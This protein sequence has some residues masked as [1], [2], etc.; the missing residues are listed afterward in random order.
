[1]SSVSGIATREMNVSAFATKQENNSL[2]LQARQSTRSRMLS[3]LFRGVAGLAACA[4]LNHFLRLWAWMTLGGEGRKGLIMTN[5]L[6]GLL[7]GLK[8]VLSGSGR[9]S[10][11]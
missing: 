10:G 1:M 5:A 4:T 11:F 6:L 3:D 2:M 8:V 7:G 9:A